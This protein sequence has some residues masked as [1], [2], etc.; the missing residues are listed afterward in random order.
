MDNY[1]IALNHKNEIW[2]LLDSYMEFMERKR[3]QVVVKSE[4]KNINFAT[5]LLQK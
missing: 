2:F 3:I 5:D 4:K 1:S